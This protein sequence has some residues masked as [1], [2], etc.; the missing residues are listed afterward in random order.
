LKRSFSTEI[1]VGAGLS[2]AMAIALDIIL[3]LIERVTTPWTR[4][5]VAR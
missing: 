1:V 5:A 3:L 2:M 4:R